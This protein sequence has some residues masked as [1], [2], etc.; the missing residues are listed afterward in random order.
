MKDTFTKSRYFYTS[1]A[2]VLRVAS[3]WA[4]PAAHI[5]NLIHHTPPTK[6]NFF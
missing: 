6:F 5:G 1:N 2:S 3:D 4:T